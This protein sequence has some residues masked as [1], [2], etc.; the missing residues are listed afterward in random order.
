MSPKA[1]AQNTDKKRV[2]MRSVGLRP[3]GEIATF[4]AVDYVPEADLEVYTA[5]ARTRWQS[6]TV[7]EEY[8]AGPGGVDGPT[9]ALPHLQGKTATDFAQY[10]DASDPTRSALHDYLAANPQPQG[11]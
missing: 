4:E 2:T 9:Q 10:G 11:E 5:D 8:D 1:K 3:D 7:S 6:V